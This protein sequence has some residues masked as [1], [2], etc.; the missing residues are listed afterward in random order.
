MKRLIL[1]LLCAA[2]AFAADVTGNWTAQINDQ[3]G[4]NLTIK[5]AFKQDGTSLSGTV[6]GPGGDLP[7]QDGKIEEDKISFAITFDGGNGPMKIGNKGTVKG[8]EITMTIEVNGQTFG[9]PV[10]LKRAK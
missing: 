3:N 7:I 10:T 8:D 4:N 2:F 9:A 5:Y 1:F 6:T